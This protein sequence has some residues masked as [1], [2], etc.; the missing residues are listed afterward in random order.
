MYEVL[1]EALGR[2]GL[3]GCGVTV[4]DRGDG[5]LMVV[6]ATVSPVMLAGRFLSALDEELK[7][8]AVVYSPAHAMRFRVALHQGLAAR[9]REGWQGPRRGPG[10]RGPSRAGA[11]HPLQLVRAVDGQ[12]VAAGRHPP[13][14]APLLED[15]AHGPP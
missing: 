11:G 4:E 14:P 7:Q 8:K 13:V 15:A 12:P 3:E 2:A 6:P 9:D 5:V 1:R 10:W